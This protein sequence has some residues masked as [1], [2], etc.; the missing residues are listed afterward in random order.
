MRIFW[1]DTRVGQTETLFYMIEIRQDN[2]KRK[3]YTRPRE[4][5][6][7]TSLVIIKFQ[8]QFD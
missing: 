3:Y 6:F 4:P 2:V 8:S 7:H 5:S 1:L